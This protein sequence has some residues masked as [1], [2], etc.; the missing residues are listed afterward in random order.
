MGLIVYLS[1][2]PEVVGIGQQHTIK[3]NSVHTVDPTTRAAPEAPDAAFKVGAKAKAK[4]E[5][6][7]PKLRH[8]KLETVA[9]KT[10]VTR[11]PKAPKAGFPKSP[12]SL[13][14]AKSRRLNDVASSVLQSGEFGERSL[15]SLGINGTDQVLL[16]TSMVGLGWGINGG[17]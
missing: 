10:S 14:D 9:K 12:P 2:Q 17:S 3:P 13:D 8:P 1:T 15:W 11:V 7:T 6:T 16:G 5:A 4:A